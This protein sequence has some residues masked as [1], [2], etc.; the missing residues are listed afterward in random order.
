VLNPLDDQLYQN[1]VTATLE[2][3]K[4]DS[5]TAVRDIRVAI[6]EGMRGR[7]F[8]SV[9]LS[10]GH[11][12]QDAPE[13]VTNSAAEHMLRMKRKGYDEFSGISRIK[14]A[15]AD[16]LNRNF[17]T[18]AKPENIYVEPGAMAMNHMNWTRLVYEHM[19][20]LD[21]MLLLFEPVYAEVPDQLDDLGFDLNELVVPV[22]LRKYRGSRLDNIEDLIISA[23]STSPERPLHIHWSSA[24]NP[25][26]TSFNGDEY[27]KIAAVANKH[28]V[29]ILED[30]AYLG[31]DY[32]AGDWKDGNVIENSARYGDHVVLSLGLSKLLGLAGERIAVSFVSDAIKKRYSELRK[33]YSGKDVEDFRSRHRHQF[34]HAGLAIQHAVADYL[35]DPQLNPRM[36]AYIKRYRDRY[37][38]AEQELQKNGFE[39]VITNPDGTVARI[40]YMPVRG[41]FEKFLRSQMFTMP[42]SIFS[43]RRE[44][45]IDGVRLAI[46]GIMD[47][48]NYELF[49]E[50]L[51]YAA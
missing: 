11:P 22:D 45:S 30:G 44:T 10:M 1:L 34:T 47:D 3:I 5:F 33:M 37:A 4:P 27:R 29:N 9:D 43:T 25:C 18:D 26:S 23:R 49:S 35:S 15:S 48:R 46:P 38:G 41:S 17:G 31:M 28:G 16:V 51:P 40:F 8:Q 2:R 19:H 39:Y 32:D 12:G 42:L 14:V 6:E 20:G 36:R 13:E 50:R 24:S 7:A 21:P